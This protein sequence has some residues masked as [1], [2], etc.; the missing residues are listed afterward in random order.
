MKE[1]PGHLRVLGIETS[2]DE[3]A[4]AVVQGGCR[5]LSN[6]LHSQVALHAPHGGVV[7]E[8]AGRSHMERILP[9]VARALE[10]A[11]TEPG[12]LDGIAVTHR[13]GL[14]GCLLVGLAVAKTL[15]LS[16]GIPL[17]GVDHVQ[18]HVHAALMTEPDLPLPLL[19]LIASGGH[20][21]LFLVEEPG[22]ALL[23]G[24][25]LDDAAGEALDKA[26]AMLGLRYPGGPAIERAA[27]EGDPGRHDFP[28]GTLGRDSLDFS[29]SG[30]KTALLYELR[31]PGLIRPFPDLS[32]KARA[33]YAASF[34][35]A[36]VETLRIKLRR[37]AERLRPRSLA[38]G[39][40]VARNRRLRRVLASDTVLGGLPLV[41][42][43]PELCSD[44]G[45]MI[46]GL[47][48]LRLARG[49]RD[50]L[51]LEAFPRSARPA[52]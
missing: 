42:P 10:E 49:E 33:D 41:L 12:N 7:P 32:G 39:G 8:I 38:I 35:E 21:C 45:A 30:L 28:R 47:G 2:C 34:Q 20:T 36:V 31:G 18:A 11:E 26:G 16:L 48:A 5:I 43:P 27:E 29:F 51:D 19:A 25:S 40:G 15:S 37:A 23:I 44:N 13:P 6:T 14:I 3:T 4:A 17:L 52:P 1:I 9:L 50:G 46:A 24:G 22:K